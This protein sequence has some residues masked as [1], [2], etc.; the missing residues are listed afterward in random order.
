MIVKP[1]LKKDKF[2]SRTEVKILVE[3][4]PAFSFKD[5]EIYND[6]CLHYNGDLYRTN[7]GE[8][9]YIFRE[10]DY[11]TLYIMNCN[12]EIYNV[13]SKQIKLTDDIAIFDSIKEENGEERYVNIPVS[14]RH[15]EG[16]RGNNFVFMK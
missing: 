6:S 14:Y 9:Y 7:D 15:I 4:M 3:G 11:C 1:N 5:E 2:I 12:K 10:L 13:L 16:F 8:E